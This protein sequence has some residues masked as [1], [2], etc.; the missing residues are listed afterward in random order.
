MKN[1]FRSAKNNGQRASL[2]CSA[3][4]VLLLT[5]PVSAESTPPKGKITFDRYYTV[6]FQE[7]HCGYG[8]T[9][10]RESAQ[11]ITFLNYISI[12]LSRMGQDMRV[13]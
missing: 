4:A 10:I 7:Q 1:W 3:L 11:Q 8:R 2:I 12:D 9:A 6:K 5:I 13:V